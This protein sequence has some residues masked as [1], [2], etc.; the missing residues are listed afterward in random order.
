MQWKRLSQVRY[1]EMKRKK[2]DFSTIPMINE[3]LKAIELWLGS[4]VIGLN[5][6]LYKLKITC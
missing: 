3:Q 1:P 4:I 6:P 5:Q 2:K